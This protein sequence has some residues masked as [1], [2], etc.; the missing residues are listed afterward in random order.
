MR[1][2]ELGNT[3]LSIQGILNFTEYWKC[4]KFRLE[5]FDPVDI[6]SLNH[7]EI[8]YIKESQKSRYRKIL[9]KLETDSNIQESI[10][11]LDYPDIRKASKKKLRS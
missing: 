6:D 10:N 8:A 11:Y 2:E 5:G 4:H 1:N 3:L 9:S 7:K